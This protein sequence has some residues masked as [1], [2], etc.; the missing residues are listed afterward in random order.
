MLLGVGSLAAKDTS[1]RGTVSAPLHS[2]TRCEKVNRKNKKSDWIC[3]GGAD[4]RWQA[5]K[6]GAPATLCAGKGR[7]RPLWEGSPGLLMCWD[8]GHNRE[9]ASRAESGDNGH[10]MGSGVSSR[11]P[12]SE[13]AVQWCAD[14][15]HL[16]HGPFPPEDQGGAGHSLSCAR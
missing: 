9:A 1:V 11:I 13:A 10:Q 5:P 15:R 6:L 16:L 12:P 14:R 8:Q 4:S 3:T 2:S 7:I